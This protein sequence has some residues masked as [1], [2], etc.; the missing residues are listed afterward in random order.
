VVQKDAEHFCSMKGQ[1][2]DDYIDALLRKEG[3][4]SADYA[5]KGAVKM[6]PRV[7]VLPNRYNFEGETDVGARHFDDKDPYLGPGEARPTTAVPRPLHTPLSAPVA[8]GVKQV[9]TP[10]GRDSIPHSGNRVDGSR[11]GAH[12]NSDGHGTGGDADDKAAKDGKG[13]KHG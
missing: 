13:A 10:A 2:L 6:D 8:D 5:G 4:T 3:R 9:I 7:P 12:G 11:G 1:V